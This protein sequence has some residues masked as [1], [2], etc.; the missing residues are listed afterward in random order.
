VSDFRLKNRMG[1]V[2]NKDPRSP[3]VIDH[4]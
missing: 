2:M 3:I 1:F 4:H